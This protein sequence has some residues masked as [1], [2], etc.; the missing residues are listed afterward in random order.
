MNDPIITIIFIR[1]GRKMNTSTY[2][3]L[4]PNWSELIISGFIQQLSE[5]YGINIESKNIRY[6]SFGNQGDGASFDFIMREL[7][8]LNFC[9]VNNLVQ[10]EKLIVYIMMEKVNLK[11]YTAENSFHNHYVHESTLKTSYDF[12]I[13]SEGYTEELWSDLGPMVLE[14]CGIIESIR[15]EQSV[16]LYKDLEDHYNT[17]L[18]LIDEEDKEEMGLSYKW[19][20]PTMCEFIQII[21]YQ[22]RSVNGTIINEIQF[23]ANYWVD[24][25]LVKIS[26]IEYAWVFS[27][28]ECISIKRVSINRED[29]P[30]FI[31]CVRILPDG[32]LV[33]Q[34]DY[35]R[36]EPLSWHD[37]RSYLDKLN[38]E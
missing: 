15:L 28:A 36:I 34:Q 3:A 29:I 14:L 5:N 33:W 30:I 35:N 38:G 18:L 7:D 25:P 26:G 11:F 24:Q 2:Y 1:K 8:I 20:L 17:T 31:I 16:K 13:D 22:V 19:R 9:K 4:D 32:E 27:N 6:H 37:V 23:G 10:F 21:D 12:S